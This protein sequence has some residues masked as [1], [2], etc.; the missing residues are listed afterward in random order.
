MMAL[1][2]LLSSSVLTLT[3]TFSSKMSSLCS[4]SIIGQLGDLS[5]TLSVP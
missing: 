5:T 3:M 2:G 1:L 4:P